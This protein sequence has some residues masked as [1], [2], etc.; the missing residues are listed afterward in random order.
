MI[1]SRMT[2]VWIL[3]TTT[4]HSS[5]DIL[6]AAWRDVQHAHAAYEHADSR[7]IDAAVYALMAAQARYDALA[8]EYAGVTPMRREKALENMRKI[9]LQAEFFS[10]R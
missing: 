9:G 2:E 1:H 5:A 7:H 8:E 4:S 10:S 6:Q 3:A